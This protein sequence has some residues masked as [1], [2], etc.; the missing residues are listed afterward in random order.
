[1]TKKAPK[2]F[3]LE[4]IKDPS[5]LA[6]L[7]KSELNDL[8]L[9]IR[10]FLLKNISKTGGHLSSNLGV[11]ELTIALHKVFNEKNNKIIFDVGHQAYTHKILTGRAKDFNTLRK[12]NGLSGYINYSESEYDVWESGHSSTSISAL[13]GFLTAKENGKDI[14]R[15]IAVIG[16]SSIASGVAFEA[17]NHLGSQKGLAPI[18][19]LNDNKMGISKSVGSLNKKFGALRSNRLLRGIKKIIRAITITPVRNLFHNSMKAIKSA[20]QYDNIFE[21]LGYDYFGPINGNNFNELIK[22]LNR[23]KKLN[24]ACVL[25]VITKKGKGY[26][27]AENDT[28]GKFHSV[29]P[30]DIK[31]GESLT[32]KLEGEYS[33]TEV[34]LDT[35]YKERENK[36]FTIIDS[37]MILGNDIEKFSK[38][39]PKSFIEVG[40]AEEHAAVLAASMAKAGMKPV[41][42][43]YSTFLQR[44]YD[45]ILNDIA[46]QNLSV[47]IGIDRAGIVGADG[48]THQGIYD[49]SMLN[50]MPN[51]KICM[52]YN[53]KETKALLK[54]ALNNVGPIAIRYPRLSDFI[55]LD[56][57][58]EEIEDETWT[59]ILDGNSAIA[60]TYG[61]DVT[62]VKNVIIDNKLDVMLINARFIKPMDLSMLEYIFE[63]NLPILVYEQVVN[64]GSLYSKILDYAASNSK[65]ATIKAINLGDDAVISHGSIDDVLDI[66]HLG[67][68]DILEGLKKL[69]EN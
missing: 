20:L 3:N 45:E 51:M 27:Y 28:T 26:E 63:Q 52:G 35:L 2:S 34:V 38:A 43:Y 49:L 10:K 54:Y 58:V 68:N 32:K 16:D 48:S 61:H 11:V 37:A 66:Y 46:R 33:Y 36:E 6:D 62:R 24:V 5:F 40:I 7:K 15:C 67:Y 55:N 53:L 59:K 60:I 1:M 14:G 44:A 29:S 31:T 4:E 19:I 22:E 69:Y 64:S 39:Y 56:L 25:H 21:T 65:N 13:E 8:A 12:T 41:L 18:I 50:G 57:E 17:L 42:L 9:D 30:F 23:I 47:L